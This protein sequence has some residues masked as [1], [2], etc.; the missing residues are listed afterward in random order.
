MR[1][2]LSL[3]HQT[4]RALRLYGF[5]SFTAATGLAAFA[6]FLAPGFL[7]AA[8]AVAVGGG[9][10]ALAGWFA[11]DSRPRQRT[12]VFVS[13]GG[14]CRDPMAK[15]ILESLIGERDP[16]IRIY[17]TA[18][19]APSDKRASKAARHVVREEMGADLLSEH[20]PLLLDESVVSNADLILTMDRAHAQ[21]I[22][23]SFPEH[24]S[25]IHSLLGFLGRSGDIEDPWLSPD[26]MDAETVARYRAC[27]RCLQNILSEN[28]DRIYSAVIA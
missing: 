11:A 25:R 2:L 10:A 8:A 6:A 21:E 27:F 4:K 23:K 22:R 20:C 15:V 18:L 14:T 5:G 13:T 26:D 7:Y 19:R 17:A 3:P 12:L 28:V 16:P 1:E 9:A 24:R